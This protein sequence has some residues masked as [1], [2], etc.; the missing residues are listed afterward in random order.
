[1]AQL[2]VSELLLDPDFIDRLKLIHRA[3]TVNS[4]GENELTETTVNTVGSIQPAPAKEFQR[5]PE[6]L[7]TSDVRAF[8]IKAAILSDGSSQY[9]DI[10]VFNSSRFQVLSVEPWLNY[11][12]G[13]NKG[14][15]VAEKPAS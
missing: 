2:D 15:A 12:S 6:A 9:P 5:L 4:F 1:M 10:I 7:R 3:S 8:Y 13:W 14:L 11:G